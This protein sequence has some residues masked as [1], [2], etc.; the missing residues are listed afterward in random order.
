M[1]VLISVQ[2]NMYKNRIMVKKLFKDEKYLFDSVNQCVPRS[3]H[4]IS[5]C[6]ANLLMLCKAKVTFF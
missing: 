5:L 3:K 2:V 1:H 4:Y 6:K